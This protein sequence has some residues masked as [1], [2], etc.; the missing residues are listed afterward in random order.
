MP[1]VYTADFTNPLVDLAD[2]VIEFFRNSDATVI[3]ALGVENVVSAAVGRFPYLDGVQQGL[4]IEA[5]RT[6]IALRS[7]DFGNVAWP[8]F[9]TASKVGATTLAGESCYQVNLGANANASFDAAAAIFQSFTLGAGDAGNYHVSVRWAGAAANQQMR[10]GGIFG[11]VANNSGT[12]TLPNDRFIVTRVPLLNVLAA[13]SGN[14]AVRPASG[15]TGQSV[16]IHSMWLEKG[17]FGGSHIPT[18]TTALSRQGEGLQFFPGGVSVGDAGGVTAADKSFAVLFKYKLNPGA[19]QSTIFYDDVDL[20]FLNLGTSGENATCCVVFFDASDSS[21][22]YTDY[23]SIQ[24][25]GGTYTAPSEPSMTFGGMGDAELQTLNGYFEKIEIWKGQ[26]TEAQML[27]ARNRGSFVAAG[28]AANRLGVATL[29]TGRLGTAKL[30][31]K[32]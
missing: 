14:I 15:A 21:A 17:S 30:G 2:G 28:G 1:L 22:K 9:S 6:N 18:T 12:V 20:G 29:G 13:T 25:M 5:A 24:Y 26:V 11:A 4:Q 8:V 32:L 23:G 16:L 27:A 10:V 31:L 3:N 19:S 7:K